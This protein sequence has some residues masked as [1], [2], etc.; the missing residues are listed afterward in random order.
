LFETTDAGGQW[1]ALGRPD[2]PSAA[3]LAVR[4][5]AV[6]LY[7]ANA[8]NGY[9][10]TSDH[11]A[12][13][14]LSLT[15]DGGRTWTV[16]PLPPVAQLF[17]VGATSY[18]VTETAFGK[19]VGLLTTRVGSARWR[20]R[21]LPVDDGVVRLAVARATIAVLQTGSPYQD[22]TPSARGRIWVSEDG[23]LHWSAEQV[24]CHGDD[25][26]AAA[27]A[28]SADDPSVLTVDC[29]DNEQSSQEQR[30]Q[31]HIY[32]SSDAGQGWNQVADPTDVGAPIALVDNGAGHVVL[33]TGSGIR[34]LLVM[35]TDGGRRWRVALALPTVGFAWGNLRFVSRSTGFVLAPSHYAAEHIY[36]T[37]DGGRD[38]ST[39]PVPPSP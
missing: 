13:D 19:P 25:G 26:G 20:R 2:L 3:R 39:L 21:A 31:H 18:A 22:D 5:G 12:T 9:L 36:R 32:R 4:E 28:M 24:P 29:Y 14:C 16:L 33:A 10:F 35:S 8:R 23:G 34:S 7:F 11:C 30:T 1:T 17:T 38:W 37:T 27:L 15:R 6:D